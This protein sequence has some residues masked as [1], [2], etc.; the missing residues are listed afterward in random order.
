[1]APPFDKENRNFEYFPTIPPS[2][3]EKTI[4]NGWAVLCTWPEEGYIDHSSFSFDDSASEAIFET[5]YHHQLIHEIDNEIDKRTERGA[6]PSG[7]AFLNIEQGNVYIRWVSREE[8]ELAKSCHHHAQAVEELREEYSRVLNQSEVEALFSAHA[9]L[10]GLFLPSPSP[11]Y[12]K[13]HPRVFV[14]G[15]ETRGWRNKTC[16]IKNEF[17]INDAVLDA[18][19]KVSQEFSSSGAKQ[20]TFLQFYRKLS[21]TIDPGSRDGALWSNQ[22]CVSHNSGSPVSLPPVEFD[23]VKKL[24]FK[25]LRAQIDILKPSVIIFTTG[26]NRDKYIK[27]CFPEYETVDIIEPR[28]LWHFKIGDVNCIRTSHPRWVEGTEYLDRAIKMVQEL[29]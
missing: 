13:I 6:L 20:S 11:N 7:G 19:M 9:E 25:L 14:V 27:E 12:F 15:Q 23:I 18:S 24:S 10:S 28:R 16:P 21:A 17:S 22:F 4:V 26:P 8:A 29:S 3:I 1:M 2:G 5:K